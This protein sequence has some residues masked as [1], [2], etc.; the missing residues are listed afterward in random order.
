MGRTIVFGYF[1]L[2][3]I[4]GMI[5][6]AMVLIFL[7][8]YSSLVLL[9]SVV[10]AFFVGVFIQY[11]G[12]Y[13]LYSGSIFDVIFNYNWIHRN[14][15]FFSYPFF[16][17]GYLINKHSWHEL[18]SLKLAGVLAVLGFFALMG[19][20]YFNYYQEN[21]DGGFDNFISL[22]MVCPAIFVFCMRIRLLGVGKNISAYSSSI[23]FVHAF[24]LIFFQS[25]TDFG[26][27]A[28]TMAVIIASALISFLVVK[29]NGRFNFIL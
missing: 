28:L 22:I 23:Y 11:A 15:L 26:G 27:T 24:A 17:L 6:A 7:R 1:H 16:C 18:V 3:Y 25:Y 19:E 4:S 9:A 21:R 10:F 2:W 29:V 14:F 20:S 12:N 13:H 8:N 5:G